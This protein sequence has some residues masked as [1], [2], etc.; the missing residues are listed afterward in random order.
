MGWHDRDGKDINLKIALACREE[1]S[2]YAGVKVYMTRDDNTFLELSDRVRY[3]QSVNADLMVS[4]HINSSDN[5]SAQG[6]LVIVPNGNYRPELLKESK[7]TAS[8]VLSNLESLGLRKPWI[9]AAKQQRKY[10]SGRL[11]GGLLQHS[12]KFYDGEY[13]EYDY[14]ARVHFQ[15]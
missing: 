4:M 13:S 14:R 7:K 3:A 1:L 6:A 8:R 5:S 9:F 11:K 2:K 12:S 10:L 15:L